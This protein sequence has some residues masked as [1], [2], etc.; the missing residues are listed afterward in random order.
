M[1]P[2]LSEQQVDRG[3]R[4]L[5]RESL[6]S[7]SSVTLFGGVFLIDFALRLG[8]SNAVIGLLAAIPF[9]AQVLQLPSIFLVERVRRRR[10]ITLVCSGTSRLGIVVLI[11]IPFLW[12]DHRGRWF[13]L[14]G[15][16]LYSV[17]VAVTMCAWNSWM[18]DLIPTDRL[19]WFSSRRMTLTTAVAM[20]LSL[21]AGLGLT[22]WKKYLPP[23]YELYG[24][25]IL[26]TLGLVAGIINLV[27]ISRVPEPGM[28]PAG[29]S[30]LESVRQPFRDVN[31]RR[32][33][34]FMGAWAFA[35]NLAAPF[36]TVYLLQTV[37][38]PVAWV[39]GL[40]LAS[41]VMNLVFF[42]VWGWFADTFSNKA[43]LRICGP[44][45]LLCVLGWT[46]TTVGGQRYW[47][48]PYL[49]V[50]IHLAMGIAT[51]GVTLGIGTMALKL[52][53]SGSATGY[54][55]ANS[56]VHSMAAGAA[57][58]VGGLLAD[59]LAR[60]QLSWNL[61]LTHEGEQW[62]QVPTL[63]LTHWDFLFAL[64]FVLG[65]YALHR[66]AL[67]S[68]K[69]KAGERIPI[70]QIVVQTRREIQNFST[71]AGLRYIV[72][73]PL[74]AMRSLRLVRFS[75]ASEAD[76]PSGPVPGVDLNLP[77]EREQSE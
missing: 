34:V 70:Q 16:G 23:E 38:Y 73:F 67:V 31:F 37:G 22:G 51:A 29:R 17:C 46:F 11:L 27:I 2:G 44:L 32:L 49:L 40:A 8:A 6:F 69:G 57:P 3:L 4:L 59:K 48:T 75:R 5:L 66:L 19:G 52:S 28:P 53:P 60:W 72:L 14:V 12:N 63:D 64:A 41:Q 15:M 1:Q 76:M 26:F 65:L 61:T 18:R 9:F 36:F 13:V 20:L 35:V 33:M 77:P 10:A 54:L 47:L 50:L 45:F 71:A 43:V 58:I 42:R 55:A 7:Q 68:E 25:S 39:I 62:W 24:Y 30:P 74:I 21:A 56:L